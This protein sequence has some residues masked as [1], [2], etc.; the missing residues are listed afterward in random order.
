MQ[1][2]E[3][4]YFQLNPMN[5]VAFQ[6]KDLFCLAEIENVLWSCVHIV[7]EADWDRAGT[8]V[9]HTRIGKHYF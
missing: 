6:K 5:C 7:E 3:S 8:T 4:A 9:H 2:L 1:L